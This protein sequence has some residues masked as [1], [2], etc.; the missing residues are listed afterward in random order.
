MFGSDLIRKGQSLKGAFAGVSS[1][2]EINNLDAQAAAL[3]Q[4][5]DVYLSQRAEKRGNKAIEQRGDRNSAGRFKKI[6]LWFFHVLQGAFQKGL[7]I[8]ES[9]DLKRLREELGDLIEESPNSKEEAKAIIAEMQ[10]QIKE[11]RM[12][13]QVV[14]QEAR[15]ASASAR[16]KNINISG[17]SALLGRSKFNQIRRVGV[18]IDRENK[19]AKHE[20]QKMALDH[21]ILALER[22]ILWYKRLH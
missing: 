21:A 6:L 3:Q 7:D 12:Q 18:R 1:F 2:E 15:I 9:I 20:N 8:K 19:Y 5:I 17:Y 16:R 11:I 4:E 14:N 22:K 10:L 13:K